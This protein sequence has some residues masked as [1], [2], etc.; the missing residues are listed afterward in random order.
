M[1]AAGVVG[2]IG[3][4]GEYAPAEFRRT[5]E[6]NLLGTLLAIHHCMP[7]LRSSRG[8]IVTFGG[9]GAATALPRYDA[10]A[11]SK[12]AVV[13]LSENLAG[14][15]RELGIRI[16]CVAPGFVATGMHQS[17]LMAGPRAAGEEYYGRTRGELKSGG[18]PASEAADLVCSLLGL[19]EDVPFSG[20]L[21][22]ARWDPWRDPDFWARLANEQDLATLRRI[23]EM[24]FTR[25]DST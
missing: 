7:A 12:A 8:S 17:T 23:D 20:K 25:I 21:I 4:I 5:I 15:L 22:S 6:V 2:P 19:E 10:Y 14:D 13:R 24:A 3:P 18:V 11:S 1:C 16:N 9:G